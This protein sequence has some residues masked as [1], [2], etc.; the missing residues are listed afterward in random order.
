MFL[1]NNKFSF[2]NLF[3]LDVANNHQGSLEHGKRIIHAF[4]SVISDSGLRVGIKFQFRHL[5]TFIHPDFRDSKDNKHISRFLSTALSE[6]EFGILLEETRRAGFITITTPFDEES[7]EMAERLNVEVIKIASC[8]AQ[9]WPLLEKIV[10]TGRP[11][12]CSTAGLAIERVDDLVSFFDK[13]MADYALMHCVAIYPTPNNK[14]NLDRIAIFK[15]RFP[16]LVV[17]FSTH[18]SPS[19]L[20]AIKVAYAKGARIFERHIG[21]EVGK[22]KLNAYSST[23]KQLGEWLNAFKEV[24]AMDSSNGYCGEDLDELSSLDSLMRGIYAKK[25]IKRGFRIMRDDVFFAMPIQ[26]GQLPSGVWDKGE[27][28]GGFYADRDYKAGE[29]LPMIL[30]PKELSEKEIIYN[31]IHEVKAMLNK[32]GIVPG[33]ES[34]VEISHHY[35]IRNFSRVGAL[36]IDCINRDYCKKLIILLPN[37]EHPYHYH[38]RKEET[39]QVLWGELKVRIE[40]KERVFYPG[41]Q[42]LM[43]R[44]IWHGF[45]TDKGVIFEEISTTHFNDDSFYAD[46]SINKMERSERKTKLIGWGR[47]QFD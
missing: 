28:R 4:S 36:I 34:S 15:E 23:P 12:I 38:K 26:K 5:D 46:K 3:V 17:G 32:A 47:H 22:I 37:Q 31:A 40:G 41:D 2:E 39:F 16:H 44:G 6:E 30:L 9:D 24:V 19:N 29:S 35:G 25:D 21:V 42:L 33:H 20:D 7:V 8:S 11:I 13:R 18:E 14:L 43:P 1:K 27:W 45:A 10:D